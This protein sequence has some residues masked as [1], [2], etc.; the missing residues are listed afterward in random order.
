MKALHTKLHS[1]PTSVAPTSQG[2]SENF[3]RRYSVKKY[4]MNVT[5]PSAV[6]RGPNRR[7]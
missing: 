2:S 3:A 7:T 5:I 4:D 6:P 1:E